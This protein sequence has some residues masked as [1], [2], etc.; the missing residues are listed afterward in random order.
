MGGDK[1]RVLAWWW[2]EANPFGISAV[3]MEATMQVNGRC[4]VNADGE[5]GAYT[6]FYGVD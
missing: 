6:K 3:S 2:L 5:F 4:I 1:G